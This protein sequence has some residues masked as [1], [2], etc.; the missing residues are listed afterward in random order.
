MGELLPLPDESLLMSTVARSPVI[1]SISPLCGICVLKPAMDAR[2]LVRSYVAAPVLRIGACPGLTNTFPR[3]VGS[4]PTRIVLPAPPKM[5]SDF[6]SSESR[7]TM[8]FCVS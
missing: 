6:T 8:A 3:F 7:C 2:R 4:L 5:V 1:V